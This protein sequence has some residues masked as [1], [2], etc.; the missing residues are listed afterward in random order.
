MSTAQVGKKSKQTL[1]VHLSTADEWESLT[2]DE[3]SYPSQGNLSQQ[4]MDLLVD[5]S[6]WVK[7]SE[8]QQRT[9]LTSP[10][11]RSTTYSTERRR[12][13]HQISPTS[14]QEV[15]DV[16][17]M[18]VAVR[19][20]QLP[21]S[22]DSTSEKGLTSGEEQHTTGRWSLAWTGRGQP[23]LSITCQIFAFFLYLENGSFINNL[24]VKIN[25]A[26]KTYFTN[27]SEDLL[28][29]CIFTNLRSPYFSYSKA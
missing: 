2:D 10:S 7:A 19:M 6:H 13:R 11:N 18:R 5:I 16:V 24:Y 8:A 12:T 26:Q 21:L 9:Q 28:T 22:E 29:V 4:M 20:R 14:I 27:Y 25:C 23:W 1:R 17:R 3:V 15:A